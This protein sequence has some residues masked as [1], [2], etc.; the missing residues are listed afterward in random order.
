MGAEVTFRGSR[1]V[2]RVKAVPSSLGRRP[3]G[4]SGQTFLCTSSH[5][6]K[7]APAPS[8]SIHWPSHLRL[9]AALFL[10]LASRARGGGC[11]CCDAFA[12][13]A[14]TLQLSSAPV[15]PHHAPLAARRAACCCSALEVELASSWHLHATSWYRLVIPWPGP[16]LS[17][18]I[19][20]MGRYCFFGKPSMVVVVH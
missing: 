16:S 5:A 20:A 15:P 11:C 19:A 14:V 1:M 3:I 18:N 10:L 9:P 17:T 7:L 4:G 2:H 12:G 8:Q 6:V 13:A